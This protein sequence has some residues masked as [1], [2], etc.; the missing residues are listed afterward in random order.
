MIYT[1]LVLGVLFAGAS[2][3]TITRGIGS[4]QA[5]V[6][7]AAFIGLTVAAFGYGWELPR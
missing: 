4:W 3:A 7:W 1:F 2:A 6:L 5:L